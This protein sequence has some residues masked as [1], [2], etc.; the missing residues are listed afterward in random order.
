MRLYAALI[1]PYSFAA[2]A[3]ASCSRPASDDFFVWNRPRYPFS[4]LPIV[5]SA[6]CSFKKEVS[7][8]FRNR[9]PLSG[10]PKESE[11]VYYSASDEDESD[12]VA[13]V[14]LDTNGPKVQ[15]NNGQ[16]SLRVEYRDGR[17]LTISIPLI[18]FWEVQKCTQSS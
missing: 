9:S 13:F 4:N 8:G 7:V 11:R 6:T 3:M 14:D 12:T 16:G 2:L 10:E 18:P 5:K 17:T 1:L 15:S